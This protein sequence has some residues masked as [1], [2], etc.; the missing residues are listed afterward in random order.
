M[1]LNVVFYNF[2]QIAYNKNMKNL[3]KIKLLIIIFI[4][5]IL[6]CNFKSVN[7]AFASTSSEINLFIDNVE[8][9]ITNNKRHEVKLTELQH[10]QKDDYK[11]KVKQIIKMKDMGFCDEEILKYLY[12]YLYYNLLL[13]IENEE[14]EPTNA[15][16][17]VI[18]NTAKIKIE[19][20]KCGIKLRKN[21]IY[22]Q[23]LYN[24]C[25][26]KQN[27]YC[28]KEE[29]EPLIKYEDVKKYS[30]ERSS[31][32]TDFSNSKIERKHNIRTALNSLDGITIY[33]NEEFSFNKTVGERN[34]ENGYMQAKIISNGKFIDAFGGGV[35]QVSTTLYN[36]ALIA[37]LDIVE[38]HSHSLKIGYI[39]PGFD[40]MVN[41]GSSDLRIRNN[42][43]FP[44]TIATSS[45]DDK[46]KI[47]L[48]GVNNNF[49][50]DRVYEFEKVETDESCKGK[51][52]QYPSISKTKLLIYCD[53]KLIEERF[54][55]EVKYKPLIEG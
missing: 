55:R 50:Y 28:C 31:F 14:L 53:N 16:I 47:S 12:P 41:S 5:L 34:D 35:C 42:T 23:I 17:C 27:I 38:V 52:I 8:Y 54:L 1:F 7:I 26:N 19:N 4:G 46:C 43:G 20:E 9:K 51:V 49:K 39:E 2:Y 33:P 40:A 30:T 21:Y 22:N 25:N 3:L 45:K 32:E 48:Y 18:P 44:I 15:K 13:T 36:A 11:L 29:I 6:L 24:F 10:S 37:G